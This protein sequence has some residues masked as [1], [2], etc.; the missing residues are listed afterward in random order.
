[1]LLASVDDLARAPPHQR[2]RDKYDLFEWRAYCQGYYMA[3][4]KTLQVLELASQRFKLRVQTRRKA[5]I[6]K[7]SA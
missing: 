2:P 6:A 3:L 5:T 1:M 4:S 7:R